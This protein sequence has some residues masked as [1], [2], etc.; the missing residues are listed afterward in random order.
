MLKIQSVSMI[1]GTQHP[2]EILHQKFVHLFTSFVNKLHRLAKC[3]KVIRIIVQHSNMCS[4]S[5]T[6]SSEST[7]QKNVDHSR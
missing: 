1:Y 6:L 3:V 5:G 7:G 2:H 4:K